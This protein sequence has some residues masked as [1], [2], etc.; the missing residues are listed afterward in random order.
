MQDHEKV[1]IIKKLNLDY[2]FDDKPEV[3]DTLLNQKLTAI[4][5]DQSY[6][7]HS[8]LP[9]IKNWTDLAEILK[10]KQ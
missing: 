9:R 6:N 3:L 8:N 4:I 5:R 10:V 2:Y 7:Q 1:E